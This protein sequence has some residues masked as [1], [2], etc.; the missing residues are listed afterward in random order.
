MVQHHTHYYT[1]NPTSPL[2]PRELTA[3]LRGRTLKFITGS[4]TFSPKRIDLGTE[5]L[6]EE[7]IVE[8]GWE[9][10]D[11][12]CGYGPVG[13]ALAKI[14]KVTMTDINE[15]AVQLAKENAKLN[16][17]FVEAISGNVYEAVKDKKFDTILL[18]PPQSAGKQLCFQMIIAAKEH[19]KKEGLLQIVARQQKGGKSLAEKMQ[20]TFG[21]M[22]IIGRGSGYTI[23]VSKNE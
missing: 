3:T 20:E 18:N 22:K 13:V 6:I 11:L 16:G 1:A 2:R 12:G 10:L 4:A 8:S 15:R 5:L 23:Y 19:L 21:N 17:V 9:V 7:S 14:A